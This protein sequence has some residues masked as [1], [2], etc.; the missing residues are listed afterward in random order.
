MALAVTATGRAQ[1]AKVRNRANTGGTGK[2]NPYLIRVGIS[3][4]GGAAGIAQTAGAERPTPWRSTRAIE[5]RNSRWRR[6]HNTKRFIATQALSR[7]ARM[8]YLR[9]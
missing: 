8:S 3:N 4:Y 9:A 6:M 7:S 1:E 5:P 2:K